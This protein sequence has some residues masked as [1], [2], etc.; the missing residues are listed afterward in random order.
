MRYQLIEAIGSGGMAEVFS[1]IAHGPS[2]FQ[3]RCV[4][5]RVLPQLACSP[6]FVQMFIDE[7]RISSLFC[8]PNIV[9]FYES[10][11]EQGVCF[12]AMEHVLGR[13]LTAVMR[14]LAHDGQLL[15][16]G[17]VAEIGRQCCLGLEY[18]HTM[19]GPDGKSLDIVHRDV[20]PSNIMIG[21]DG[22][23]KLLDFGIARAV[24]EA[25][26]SHTQEG[27]I[28]GKMSYVAPEQL[29]RRQVDRRCDIFTLGVVLHELLTG[30]R[31][32]CGDTD[33]QSLRLILDMPIPPPSTANPA[34]PQELDMI[35]MRAL[36]RDPD[37][38]Y[39]SAGQMATDL[40]T[41]LLHGPL[42]SDA[43]ARMMRTLF[44]DAA[45][46]AAAEVDG[47]DRTLIQVDEA[48]MIL[49]LGAPECEEFER[50]PRTVAAAVAT[51]AAPPAPAPKGEAPAAEARDARTWRGWLPAIRQRVPLAAAPVFIAA[52]MILV[53]AY[54]N[55]NGVLSLG[56]TA[57][58]APSSETV[59]V[60]IDSVPQGATVLLGPTATPLGQ[61]P[62]VIDLPRHRQMVEFKLRKDGYETA[63]LKIIPSQDKPA[64]VLLREDTKLMRWPTIA[65]P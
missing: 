49:A 1:A 41:F 27:V 5:K 48:D 46:A 56:A 22:V 18:A 47:L 58:A 36:H 57:G 17:L 33:L 53:A 23:L 21:F 2:G 38:R 31:L 42:P 7:A 24:A 45:R 16:P 6:A 61:T 35:V 13:D 64:L 40:E 11:E 60:S 28:K 25:R 34:V 3:R 32:F 10:G 12:L 39:Q 4:V 55:R 29:E 65:L 51:A 54:P 59:L 8:H 30:R 52:L 44:S 62:V 50:A 14:T 19:T 26:S 37:Q 9:Q 63:T 20:T 43:L 15:A